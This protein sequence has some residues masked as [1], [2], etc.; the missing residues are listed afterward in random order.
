MKGSTEGVQFGKA[1]SDGW[2]S[3][4][5]SAAAVADQYSAE[6]FTEFR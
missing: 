4:F 6:D 3:R 5:P 2:L 1:A